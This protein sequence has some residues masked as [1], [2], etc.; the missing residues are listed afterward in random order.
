MNQLEAFLEKTWDALLSRE[1]QRIRQTFAGLDGNSQ[2]VVLEHLKKMVSESGWQPEQVLSARA[3][4]EALEPEE[5]SKDE[6]R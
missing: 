2:H 1:P 3:A 6:P 5:R 4:L